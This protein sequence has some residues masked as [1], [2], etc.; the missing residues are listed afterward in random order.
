MQTAHPRRSRSERRRDGEDRICRSSRARAGR[1]VDA[2]ECARP[3]T[4]VR[5]LF[6]DFRPTIDDADVSAHLEQRG[7]EPG[8]QRNDHH[9]LDHDI[10]AGTISAATIGTPLTKNRPAR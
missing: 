6:A 7:Q 8:A 9:A 5:D 4:Q 10:G 3:H 2:L 1:H